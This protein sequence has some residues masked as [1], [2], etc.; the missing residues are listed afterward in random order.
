MREMRSLA[1]T[2]LGSD[3]D[4]RTFHDTI[5]NMGSVP[6][7]TFESE[8]KAYIEAEKVRVKAKASN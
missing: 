3:F 8:M 4:Q 2:E 1:E 6:L 5:L 7:S